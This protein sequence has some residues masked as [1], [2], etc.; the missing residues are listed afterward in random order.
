M[1]KQPPQLADQPTPSPLDT[2]VATVTAMAEQR[3]MLAGMITGVLAP[4]T[5]WKPTLDDLEMMVHENVIIGLRSRWVRRVAVPVFQARRALQAKGEPKDNA[6]K[7]ME[8]L[9]QCTD[10]LVKVTCMRWIVATY[11]IKGWVE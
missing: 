10:E 8:I 2:F 11:H 1:M 3:A 6:A 9:D 4:D 5:P 7:A